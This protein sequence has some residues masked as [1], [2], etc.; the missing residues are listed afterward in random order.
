[1]AGKRG[2]PA[3]DPYELVPAE[4]KDKIN[5]AADLEVRQMIAQVSLN[6]AALMEAKEADE[7]LKQAKEAAKSAGAVYADGTKTNKQCISYGRDLLKARGKPTGDS[8]IEES[9]A[10]AV[11][12]ALDEINFSGTPG[13]TVTV[14][15]HPPMTLR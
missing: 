13:V 1:M 8:G 4:F 2:R 5:A 14:G 6:Q 12:L 15:T 7:D 9:P 10:E 3:K 11:S